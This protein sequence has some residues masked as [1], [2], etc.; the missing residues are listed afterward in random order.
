M[1][2]KTAA[3]KLTLEYRWVN[4]TRSSENFLFCYAVK[5]TVFKGGPSPKQSPLTVIIHSSCMS[6]TNDTGGL[7]LAKQEF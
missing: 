5:Q 3:N 2:P 7:E 6:Y 1:Y 4:V